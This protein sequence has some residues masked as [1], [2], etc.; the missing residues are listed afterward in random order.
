MTWGF[1]EREAPERAST[2]R[3]RLL[4]QFRIEIF[5]F[6]SKPLLH[7]PTMCASDSRGADDLLYTS[8][9]ESYNQLIGFKVLGFLCDFRHFLLVYLHDQTSMTYMVANVTGVQVSFFLVP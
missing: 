8:K 4:Q 5:L 2:E 9:K 6:E 3:R 1:E 7:T